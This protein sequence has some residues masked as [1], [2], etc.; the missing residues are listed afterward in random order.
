MKEIILNNDEYLTALLADINKATNTIDLEVYI[1]EDD[2]AGKKVAD[3][4]CLAAKTRV[5]ICFLFYFF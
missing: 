2:T 1:F 3:A 5:K 4:L